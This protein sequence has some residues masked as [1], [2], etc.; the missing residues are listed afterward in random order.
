MLDGAPLQELA[1][2]EDYEDNPTGP[3]FQNL[4][5]SL[6]HPRMMRRSIRRVILL[7]PTSRTQTT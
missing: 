3:F 6:P 5:K 7:V 4:S 1:A 2:A